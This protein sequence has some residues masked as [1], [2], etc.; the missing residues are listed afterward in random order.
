MMLAPL[1]ALERRLLLMRDRPVDAHLDQLRVTRDRVQWRAKLVTHDGEKLAL[2][3]V[4]RLGLEAR[5]LGV[6]K[7]PLALLEHA[8]ASRRL[9][10]DHQHTGN[11]AILAHGAEA[12]RPPGI[13]ESSVALDR[14]KLVLVP[15]RQAGAH[16]A[17]YLRTD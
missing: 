2:R 16:H 13:F 4:C 1:D 12:V 7:H 17:L 9:L 10:A 11:P 6:G 8:H 14:Q 5:A 15:R 3:P